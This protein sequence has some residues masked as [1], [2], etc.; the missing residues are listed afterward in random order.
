LSK[1][2]ETLKGN[3]ILRSGQVQL[4]LD[5]C[6][7][8]SQLSIAPVEVKLVLKVRELSLDFLALYVFQTLKLGVEVVKLTPAKVE[9]CC[10][11]LD[12]IGWNHF[13]R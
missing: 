9:C 12:L 3:H 1:L 7:L 5:L 13:D 6:D 10:V 8:T 11:L 2:Q 4:C